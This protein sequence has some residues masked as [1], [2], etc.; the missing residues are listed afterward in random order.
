M[1]SLVVGFFSLLFLAAAAVCSAQSIPTFN[2]DIAPIVW[3][4]CASCHRP[5]DVAPFSL[6]TYQDVRPRLREIVAAVTRR[7]MP[8]WLPEPAAEEFANSRRLADAAIQTIVKWSDA[9]GPEGASED[10]PQ[11]PPWTDGW[12]LGVPDLVVETPEAFVLRA[13]QGE[14]FRSFVVPVPIDRMRYVRGIE[15]R[16]G[17]RRAVHHA[18]ITID[19][20]RESRRLDAADPEA[21]FKSGMLSDGA[22]SPDNRVLGWTP[23]MRATFEPEGMAWRLN[24]GSDLVIELH[25]IAPAAGTESVRPS[26]GFYFSDTPPTRP[27]IDFKLGSNAIDI[28]AGAA[29]YTIEDRYQLPV[30]VDVVSVYPHA[31][32]LAK[33]V[34]ADAVLPGGETRPLIRIKDWDFHWQDD[35]RFVRPVPLPRGTTI[36]MHY[37]YDNSTANRHNPRATPARVIYGPQSSDEMGD[38]WL[39]LVPHSAEDA[40]TLAISYRDRER[41]K[42]V[43]LAEQRTSE[44]PDD[45]TWRNAL[46]VAYLEAGRLDDSIVELNRALA[47]APGHLQAHNNLGQA[48]RQR[49]LIA[50]AVRHFR[51]SIAIAPDNEI[52]WL[53]LGNA[54]EDNADL[55]EAIDA[56]EHALRLRPDLVEAHNNLGIAL[57]A[58]GRTDEAERAFMS[59]LA[60]DPDNP[61][62]R[63]NLTLLRQMR[64]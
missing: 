34:R 49:G 22:R 7:T 30:D 26:V 29:A 17:N 50:E 4:H 28:P 38:L 45:A 63:R 2:R 5:G 59:A 60:A 27:S 64:R 1:R 10:L 11:R 48:L 31:H 62:A 23:G 32:Y 36:V 61:D 44:H 19:R 39:R 13:G 25:L 58:L 51:A 15:V 18:S 53:N 55:A 42:N 20:T 35:Y 16:P 14:V 9:G 43:R 56:F 21:G 57:G 3:A 46:G 54:Y 40:A 8:P 24:P 52:L 41:A 33:D 6:L 12:Q 37:E 47:L